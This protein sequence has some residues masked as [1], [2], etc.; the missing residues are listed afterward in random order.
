MKARG[1]PQGCRPF[2]LCPKVL[3]VLNHADLSTAY[4]TT[5]I[6]LMCT[7]GIRSFLQSWK[8]GHGLSRSRDVRHSSYVVITLHEWADVAP[9]NTLTD[10]VSFGILAETCP[11]RFLSSQYWWLP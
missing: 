6:S 8:K 5:Q 10:I 7:N 2:N 3:L 4:L 1:N 9:C 11:G